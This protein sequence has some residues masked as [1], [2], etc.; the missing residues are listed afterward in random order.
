LIKPQ[1]S[2]LSINFSKKSLFKGVCGVTFV[3]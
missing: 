3:V 1:E 2:I